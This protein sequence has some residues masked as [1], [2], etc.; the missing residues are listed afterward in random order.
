MAKRSAKDLARK[1]E[2]ARQREAERLKEMSPEER[3][4][5]LEMKR[6]FSRKT[7]RM[8]PIPIHKPSK[9]E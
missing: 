7:E 9:T 6:H 3:E 4:R 1:V 8:A 2:E 5:Y